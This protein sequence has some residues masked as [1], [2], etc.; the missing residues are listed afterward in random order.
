MRAPRSYIMPRLLRAAILALLV[1]DSCSKKP[2]KRPLLPAPPAPM[3]PSGAH[4]L[5]QYG[6]EAAAQAD[7]AYAQ[8]GILISPYTAQ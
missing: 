1:V 5:P 3:L 7:A 6:L 4:A 2:R 8:A